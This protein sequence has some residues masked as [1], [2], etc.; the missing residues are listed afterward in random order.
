MKADKMT[1]ANSIEL[2]VPFLDHR[3]VEWISRQD[4]AS[5]LQV[6]ERDVATRKVLLRRYARDRLPREIVE[7]PKVGFA[8]PTM[9]WVRTDR[10]GFRSRP[11]GRPGAWV[12]D[13]FSPTVI[14]EISRRAAVDPRATAQ[15]WL[16]I[17]L[18][19]WAQRWL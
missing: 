11:L 16:L 10:N 7:R 5:K 2:R 19:N 4:D 14:D 18:E 6:D 13:R 12:R 1:M 15:A 3:L 17:V 8:T 9:E